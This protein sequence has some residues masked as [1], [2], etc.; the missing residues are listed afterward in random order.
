MILYLLTLAAAK[1]SLILFLRRIFRFSSL[2]YAMPICNT[3]IAILALWG[4]GAA[5]AVSV[6][7]GPEHMWSPPGEATCNGAVGV[8][9]LSHEIEVSADNHRREDGWWSPCPTL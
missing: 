9:R 6:N 5:V 2:S 1:M 3:S 8:V 4:I 7:C